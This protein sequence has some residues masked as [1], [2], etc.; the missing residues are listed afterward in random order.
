MKSVRGFTLVELMVTLTIMVIVAM[1]VAPSFNDMLLKQDLNSSSRSLIDTLTNARSKAALERRDVQV[2][3]DSTSVDTD[4][5]ISWR[6]KNR[7]LYTSST[8]SVTFRFDGIVETTTNQPI[9][10]DIVLRVCDNQRQ[11]SKRIIIN[12]FGLVQD[13]GFSAGCN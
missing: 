12:R 7:S 13:A 10:Q 3:L 11:N 4:N 5:Q 9:A 2:N 1:M 8:Q 6:P